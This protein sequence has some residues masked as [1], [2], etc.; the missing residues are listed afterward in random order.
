MDNVR[1]VHKLNGE[2]RGKNVIAII[3]LTEKKIWLRYDDNLK[4]K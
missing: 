2:T 4:D 3:V 1:N